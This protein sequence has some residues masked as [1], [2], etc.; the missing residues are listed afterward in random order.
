MKPLFI[1]FIFTPPFFKFLCF[2][3][4]VGKL[5]I[6]LNSV[7]ELSAATDEPQAEFRAHALKSIGHCSEF[8]QDDGFSLES[9]T[10]LEFF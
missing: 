1:F 5:E 7:A 3:D 2:S 8:L 10:F 4:P 6:L 9:E